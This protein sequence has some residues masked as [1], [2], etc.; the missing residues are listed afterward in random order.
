MPAGCACE[1]ALAALAGV[2]PIPAS[3]GQVTRYRLNRGGDRQLNRALHTI[4]LVRLRTDLTL[5]PTWPGA[6]P[7]A[8]AGATPSGA[9]GASSPASCTACWSATTDLA[10]RS[11]GRLDST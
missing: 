3:S 9:Y 11:S 4:L 2:N 6:P 10:S 1:A 5:A 8:R 7:R